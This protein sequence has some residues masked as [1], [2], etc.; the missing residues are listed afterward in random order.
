MPPSR[1]RHQVGDRICRVGCNRPHGAWKQHQ[2]ATSIEEQ[3]N[4]CEGRKS[5]QHNISQ[6]LHALGQREF[7]TF[8]LTPRQISNAVPASDRHEPTTRVV[9]NCRQTRAARTPWAL[10]DGWSRRYHRRGQQA[11]PSWHGIQKEAARRRQRLQGY[12]RRI[13]TGTERP[14]TNSHLIRRVAQ[15]P[16]KGQGREPRDRAHSQSARIS[17]L[18]RSAAW[19]HTPVSRPGQRQWL[20]FAQ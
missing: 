16:I 10:T 2:P 15:P 7:P 8:T 18:Y 9:S 6:K 20:R 4:G 1:D 17:A 14:I 3:I 11:C 19:Q 12:D 13:Q 5:S